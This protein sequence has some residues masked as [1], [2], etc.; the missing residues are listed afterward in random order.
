MRVAAERA[1]DGLDVLVWCPQ[2]SPGGGARLL[3][4]L[5]PAM[6]RNEQVRSVR[7]ASPPA[8]LESRDA[9]LSV[10][11][12]DRRA[13]AATPDGEQRAALV[14]ANGNRI[15]GISATREWQ[16]ETTA[17]LARRRDVVYAFWAWRPRPTPAS[18]C[19]DDS[20]HDA[21]GL[22][23]GR[24]R[25]MGR[26]ADETEEWLD[27]AAA[28]V[29]SSQATRSCLVRLFGD[30]GTDAVVVHHAIRPE[31]TVPRARLPWQQ[32]PPASRSY[33][34]FAGNAGTRRTSSWH[35]APGPGSISATRGRSS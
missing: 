18:A 28:I 24:G 2:V 26:R 7:L 25:R 23:R 6:A 19:S 32:T 34:L 8:A 29:V 10:R 13:R 1:A 30:A 35:C 33:I 15:V 21:D 17:E 22:S 9:R 14:R 5:L 27:A 3:L 4:S 11:R 16:D 20:G 31:V 12:G